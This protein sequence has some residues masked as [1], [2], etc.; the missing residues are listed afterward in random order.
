M[1]YFSS[2]VTNCRVRL[3]SKILVRWTYCSVNCLVQL[4]VT[5]TFGVPKWAV[6]LPRVLPP[7]GQ[8]KARSHL[9]VVEPKMSGWGN[10]NTW[11]F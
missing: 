11:C 2:K 6:L 3:A 4:S 7:G 10:C 5:P 8:N 1:F 9:Y